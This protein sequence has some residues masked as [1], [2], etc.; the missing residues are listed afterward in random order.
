[1]LMRFFIITPYT[2]DPLFLQKKQ[3]IAKISAQ[4]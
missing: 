2:I 3:I 4:Y 1:M